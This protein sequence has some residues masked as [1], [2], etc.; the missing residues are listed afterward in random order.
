[1]GSPFP[2]AGR[3]RGGTLAVPR[4]AHAGDAGTAL[5]FHFVNRIVSALLTEDLLPGG[6]QRLRPVRSAAGRLPARRVRRPLRPGVSLPLLDPLPDPGETPG[7]AR[8]TPVGPAYAALLR[9]SMGGARLLDDEELDLVEAAVHDW[10]GTHPSPVAGVFPDRRERPGARLAT[11][12][13]LAPYRIT[14]EDVVAW[15]RPEHTDGDLV[16][17]VAYGAFLAVDRVESAAGPVALRQ[18]AGAPRAR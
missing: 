11:P 5:A 8:G 2:G 14:D 13:A 16:R 7:W 12:A 1:M 9:A 15:R 18:G 10:D 17:L 3:P 4:R 6:A